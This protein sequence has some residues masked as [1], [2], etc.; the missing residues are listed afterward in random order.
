MCG[1]F[2]AKHRSNINN[3]SINEFLEIECNNF[4]KNRGP[5]YQEIYKSNTLFIYQST[6]A[7][8]S[9]LIKSNKLGAIGSKKFILYNGEI[10]GLHNSISDTEYIFDLCRRD[11]LENQINNLD[12]MFIICNFMRINNNEIL[13]DAYRDPA[14]EK[15]MWYYFDQDIVLLSSV[16]AIIRKY[17]NK[18]AN[19]KINRNAIDDYLKRRHLISPL[20]HPIK[21]LNNLKPGHKLSFNSKKWELVESKY[22]NYEN[23][24][25]IDLYKELS[26][27]SQARYNAE[28]KNIFLKTLSKME[29]A[30]S[31][32]KRSSS[33]ISGGFDSSIIGACLLNNDI[34]TDIYTMTF[35]EKDPVSKNVKNIL[36]K[37]YKYNEINHKIID[38][39]LES[40]H[41]SLCR[42]I[43]IL[44][45][46]VNTHSIPSSYLVAS[47]A[48]QDGNIILYGGEGADEIFLGYDCYGKSDVNSSIY[49]AL[50]NNYSFDKDLNKRVIYSKTEKYIQEFKSNIHDYLSTYE[51]LDR[52]EINIKTESFADIFIQLSSVG[53]L[54]TDTVNSDL[55]IECRTP[56]VR[57]ELLQFGIS[58]PILKLINSKKQSLYKMPIRSKFIDYFGAESIMPKIGFAGFPNE[59]K[60]ILGNRKEWNIWNYLNWSNYINQELTISE[61]WKLINLE[62]FLRLIHNDK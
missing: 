25:S 42:S 22:F 9:K 3:D 5:S 34:K 40:Y 47:K 62:W 53:L 16:P 58:S 33:I 49:N 27:M 21:N 8:Q 17:L 19:L 39:T 44:S 57:R 41:D 55:G 31:N 11:E 24:F 23:L 15:H 59:T 12:G 50:N 4:I 52:K 38:C 20:D 2:F 56:F 10:F 46:P 6:L 32:I 54:S 61:E 36:N 14:G 7:I 37:N 28:F 1:F 48:Q 45:S 29:N 13:F 51:I 43:D 60:N 18:K 35:H 26:N 30:S